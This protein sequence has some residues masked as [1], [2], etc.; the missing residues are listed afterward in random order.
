MDILIP[1]LIMVIFYL[2]PELLKRHRAEKSKPHGLY[3]PLVPEI[4]AV[5]SKNKE[6]IHHTG[7]ITELQSPVMVANV[8][9]VPI[10]REEPS[11][12]DEK[13]DHNMLINGVIF[14]E[15]LQLPRAYRPFGKK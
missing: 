11:P 3:E 6:K 9:S 14:A 13:L 5:S 7:S 8:Q 15:I 4:K 12:W 1:L 2:G 10:I